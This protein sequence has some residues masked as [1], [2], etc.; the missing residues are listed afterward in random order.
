LADED[1]SWLQFKKREI[2]SR[3]THVIDC[4]AYSSG[5]DV[6][7]REVSIYRVKTGECASF[8]IYMPIVLFDEKDRCVIYQINRVHGLPIVRS[9]LT[10]DF[11]TF[12]EGMKF[13]T[14][15]FTSSNADLIAYKGGDIERNLLNKMGVKCLNLEVFMCPKYADLLIKYGY[16]AEC[17]PYHISDKFHCSKHEVRVFTVF[18][19][20]Q[21]AKT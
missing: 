9:K 7:L 5:K 20:D 6:F 3:I 11:F 2:L 4:E 17:C 10:Y 13:M 15:E 19:L 1:I 12:E 18:I 8:Q 16:V 14:D 21:I